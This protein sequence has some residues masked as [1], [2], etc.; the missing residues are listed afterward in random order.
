LFE[1]SDQIA[2]FDWDL[3]TI[4]QL[5]RTLSEELK[6]ETTLVSTPSPA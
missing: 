4:R 5:H 3:T 2:S 6:K 1:V